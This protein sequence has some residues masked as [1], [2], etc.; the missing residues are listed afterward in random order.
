MRMIVLMVVLIV[1]SLTGVLC[2]VFLSEPGGSSDDTTKKNPKKEFIRPVAEG[3]VYRDG[4]TASPR[5][6]FSSCRIEKMKKGHLTFPAFDVLAIDNLVINALPDLIVPAASVPSGKPRLSPQ[7]EQWASVFI[8]RDRKFSGMRIDNFQLNRDGGTNGIRPFV[9]ARSATGSRRGG[10]TLQACRV[11]HEDGRTES[12]RQA[13]LVYESGV[14]LEYTADGRPVRLF[15][16]P[17]M[18]K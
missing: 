9:H 16:Y 2:F 11:F 4:R 6:S 12:I 14:C 15:L 3:V 13:R 10:L 18:T 1:A 7:I 5:I 8:P 17:P